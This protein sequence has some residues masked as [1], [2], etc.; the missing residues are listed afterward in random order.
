MQ[1]IWTE[2]PFLVKSVTDI[3]NLKSNEVKQQINLYI[4]IYII[5]NSQSS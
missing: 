4:P 1:F 5:F 2:R 3:A